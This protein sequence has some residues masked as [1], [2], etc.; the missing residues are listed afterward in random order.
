M[1]I[2]PGQLK[3]LLIAMG[4]F[5][6]F[7]VLLIIYGLSKFFSKRNKEN[8]P[9]FFCQK[10]LS[11]VEEHEIVD[12]DGQRLCVH[13]YAEKDL[14]LKPKDGSKAEPSYAFCP[15]CNGEIPQMSIK[16]EHCEYDFNETIY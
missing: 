16:C 12:L 15:K 3:I 8:G 7:L 2:D 4:G 13:C 6:T 11:N 14:E 5:G 9:Q 10:C 1:R